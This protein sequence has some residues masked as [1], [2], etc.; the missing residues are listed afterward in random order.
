MKELQLEN[1]T[2]NHLEKILAEMRNF[3]NQ[4]NKKK[5]IMNI[6]QTSFANIEGKFN[7]LNNEDRDDLEKDITISELQNIV[8]NSKNKSPGPDG[9]TNEFYKTFWSSLK[10]VLLSLLNTYRNKK[11]T[12]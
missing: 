11:T 2:V 3:Y 9:Y 6:D 7:K 8:N 10:V 5:N 12:Q 4:L 1:I